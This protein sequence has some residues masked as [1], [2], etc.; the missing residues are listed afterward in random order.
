MK[1][2]S[3][4]FIIT[5]IVLIILSFGCFFVYQG[6]VINTYKNLDIKDIHFTG[7]SFFEPTE[8]R[9]FI[10]K[11]ISNIP[12]VYFSSY[13]FKDKVFQKIWK[14]YETISKC[15]IKKDVSLCDCKDKRYENDWGCMDLSLWEKN[16]I[17][18]W[19]VTFNDKYVL[20]QNPLYAKKTLYSN[21]YKK[22]NEIF[23]DTK[24]FDMFIH[25]NQ[26]LDVINKAKEDKIITDDNEYT[27][28]HFDTHS[29]FYLSSD[30]KDFQE[31]IAD[32]INTLILDIPVTKMYWIL[33]DWT[34][35]KEVSHIFWKE[36][37]AE[38]LVINEAWVEGEKHMKVYIDENNKLFFIKPNNFD[39]K[40]YKVVD[41]FK[42][43]AHEI[44]DFL[45][46]D[47]YIILDIDEDYFGNVGKDTT[48]DANY[49]YTENTLKKVL[50]DFIDNLY[51]KHIH[52]EIVTISRSPF[53]TP[54]EDIPIIE[55]FFQKIILYLEKN[56]Y[57]FGYKHLDVDGEK[58]NGELIKRDTSILKILFFMSYVD[59]M[60]SYPDC[61]ISIIDHNKEFLFV[62]E[63]MMQEFFDDEKKVKEMLYKLDYDDTI[64]DG[65]INICR[66]EG[67]YNGYDKVM[68]ID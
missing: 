17:H 53:Y 37:S 33:P 26:T 15:Y 58:I 65:I 50:Y 51:K 40:I 25:H 34:L 13:F 36:F 60:S 63:K 1:N 52:P 27:I 2:T 30:T 31:S 12:F 24:I 16:H 4:V 8:V 3:F 6:I 55:G 22:W 18:D 23:N 56:D 66:L 38:D 44:P 64:I 7:Y 20:L 41:F 28:L 47:T 11:N 49:N 10:D 42:I 61:Q 14:E 59:F 46:D 68:E 19:K 48:G 43:T 5:I 35:K 29:D 57:L 39:D 21:Q 9:V 32:Y 45:F 62:K 67:L 54:F